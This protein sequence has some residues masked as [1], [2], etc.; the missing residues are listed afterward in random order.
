MR[1]AGSELVV[2]ADLD[3]LPV[4]PAWA[5]D[6][7]GLTEVAR[8]R[9]ATPDNPRIDLAHYPPP[10]QDPD[11]APRQ[12][13]PRPRSTAERQFLDLGAGSH[14]WLVDTAHV[15]AATAGRF[16]ED[17][18]AS[19]VDHQ[20]TGASP[21]ELV[22]ADDTHSAQPG[23]SAWAGFTMTSKGPTT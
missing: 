10:P 7:H 11:G 6:R 14:A 5:G 20:A 2:V 16:D 8:H 12:P 23:T 3:V 13:R 18:L 19:I 22:V 21:A 4:A 9:F 15:V 17:D 1:A